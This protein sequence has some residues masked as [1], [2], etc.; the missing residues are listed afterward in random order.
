MT[1]FSCPVLFFARSNAQLDTRSR[2]TRFM[3]QLTWFRQRTAL[4]GV[5]TMSDIIWMKC[6]PKTPKKG[7]EEAFSNQTRKNTKT[8]IPGIIE[9]TASIPTGGLSHCAKFGWNRYSSFD[10]MQVLVFRDLG[11]KTPIHAPKIGV[12]EGFDPLNGQLSHRDPQK[13]LPCAETRHMTYRSSKSVK[14]CRLGAIPR[15]K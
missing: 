1:F 7:R 14:Q 15:I 10:N 4:F 13:A 3:A 5:R 6:A 11:L 8:C 12:F 9:T 2:Y